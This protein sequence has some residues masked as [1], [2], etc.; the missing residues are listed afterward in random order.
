MLAGAGAAHADRDVGD[1]VGRDFGALALCL[2]V[3]IEGDQHVEVAVADV[4]HDHADQTALGHL[5]LGGGDAICQ[6]RD[7][8]AGVGRERLFARHIVHARPVRIVARLP[9][10]AAVFGAIG[11]PIVAAT[12]VGGDRLHLLDLLGDVG[13]GAVELHEQ[14]W[15]GLEAFE[16]AVLDRGIHLHFIEQFDARHRD[17][18]LHRGDDATHGAAQVVELADRGA[19]AL[20]YAVELELDLGDDAE[21]AFAANIEARQVIA[22]TRFLCARP[23]P[24]DAAVGRDHR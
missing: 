19:D 17:A 20:R 9:E 2:A 16:L 7:R 6:A 24:D 11:E 1:A 5:V 15:L 23:G 12:E 22:R 4:A 21:R 10:L 3:R 8:H 18:K 13:V 14:R